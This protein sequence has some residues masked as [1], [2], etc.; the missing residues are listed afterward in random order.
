MCHIWVNGLM[1]K[2]SACQCR[3]HRRHGFKP[4]VRKIP[5]RRK[6]QPI[7]VFLPG[8]SHGQRSLAGYSP[9]GHKESDMTKQL[10]T[11][12]HTHTYTHTPINV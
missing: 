11:H 10:N 4:W 6:W 5:L 7:L 1:G 2:E 3:R 8:K 12:T 9:W